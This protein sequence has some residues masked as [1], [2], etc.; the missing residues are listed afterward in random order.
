MIALLTSLPAFTSFSARL[1]R[2]GKPAGAKQGCEPCVARPPVCAWPARSMPALRPRTPIIAATADP[3]VA[4]RLAVLSGVR[5]IVTTERDVERLER[6]VL[7]TR[8]VNSGSTVVF[9][10]VSQDLTR[11]ETNFL[12]VQRVS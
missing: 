4:A 7:D 12:N 11:V 6:V 8:L 10:N 5:P 3:K 1:G 9:I 2:A